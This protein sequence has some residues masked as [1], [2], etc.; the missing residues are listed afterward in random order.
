MGHV[1]TAVAILRS[2]THGPAWHGASVMDILNRVTAEQAEARPLES[3]HTIWEILNHMI[4][5]SEYAVR[6]LEGG[7]ATN[8][9]GD[10]DWPPVRVS[11]PEQWRAAVA[12]FEKSADRV[13]A[14]VGSW[15]EAQLG[16]T[17]QG[18]EITF[19]V[20][21]H[22]IAHHNTYHSGQIGV[23]LAGLRSTRG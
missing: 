15:T 1:S 21:V 7:D 13:I 5:W 23:L 3:A 10:A 19:K 12:R 16:A 17:V 8:M 22:G 6:V 9:E 18:R 14:I 4:A 20:L 11:G 2:V